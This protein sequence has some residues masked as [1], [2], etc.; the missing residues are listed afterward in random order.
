[1]PILQIRR[2][3][4]EQVKELEPRHF[5]SRSHTVNHQAKPA[6]PTNRET[7]SAC[8]SDVWSCDKTCPEAQTEVPGF[9]LC[10]GF[11]RVLLH[12]CS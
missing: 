2:L 10:L 11:I 6:P 1:M 7:E 5:G 9:L 8:Q 3:R 12:G 4:L